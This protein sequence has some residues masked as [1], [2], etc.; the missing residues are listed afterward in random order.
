[1]N[2]VKL[3][4]ISIKLYWTTGGSSSKTLISLEI[5]NS[6]SLLF[7]ET[8]FD[9]WKGNQRQLDDILVVGMKLS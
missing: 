7:I 9:K 5:S 2:G 1:M 4:F 8:T 3:S 6:P